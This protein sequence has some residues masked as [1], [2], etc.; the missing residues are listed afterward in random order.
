MPSLP[1]EVLL[2]VFRH[3]S[4]DGR[5]KTLATVLRVSKAIYAS[6][7]PFLFKKVVLTAE[8]AFLVLPGIQKDTTSTSPPITGKTSR[9]KRI[10]EV[11]SIT[12]DEDQA[13][14]V[15]DRFACIQELTIKSFPSDR[16]LTGFHYW[17]SSLTPAQRSSLNIALEAIAIRAPSLHTAVLTT[18]QHQL[19][20]NLVGLTGPDAKINICVSSK[21]DTFRDADYEIEGMFDENVREIT[22]SGYIPR[23]LQSKDI[24]HKLSFHYHAVGH[25]PIGLAAASLVRIGFLS[26]PDLS[27]AFVGS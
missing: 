4:K 11:R 13:Q 8:N 17:V 1:E 9:S 26:K 2:N 23:Y 27:D 14:R 20:A 19:L 5:Y 18:K 21:E 3:L 12:Y 22:E 16:H 10:L 24:R 15:I 25:K 7:A 6:V